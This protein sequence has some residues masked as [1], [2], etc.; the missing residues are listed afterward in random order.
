M[1]T[2][3]TDEELARNIE[4]TGRSAEGIVGFARGELGASGGADT[5]KGLVKE[6][7][8]EEIS[9]V[10]KSKGQIGD[11]SLCGH[12]TVLF[13]GIAEQGYGALNIRFDTQ[14][15]L[16][17]ADVSPAG[18]HEAE[19]VTEML[20]DTVPGIR[21]NMEENYRVLYIREEGGFSPCSP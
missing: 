16:E 1:S 4:K 9:A 8:V 10:L 18:T 20:R 17:G 15:N 2:D 7:V 19:K 5:V 14:G 21:D 12:L 13:K 11:P 3:I 6:V